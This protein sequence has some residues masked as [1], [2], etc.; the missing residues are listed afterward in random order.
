M[1]LR[2]IG[3]LAAL[4]GAALPAAGSVVEDAV[5]QSA[6]LIF[7]GTVQKVGGSN[8][9]T[10]PASENTV[11]VRVNE[12]FKSPPALDSIAGRDV[13]LQQQGPSRLKKGQTAVF[14]ASGFV[15]GENLGLKEVATVV[16]RVDG[17]RVGDQIARLAREEAEQALAARVASAALVVAG[18]VLQVAPVSAEGGRRTSEHD[19]ELWRAE[20]KVTSVEKGEPPAGGSVSVLFARSTDERWL[21]APKLAAQEAAIFLLQADET[22]ALLG[23]TGYSVLHRLDVQP[24]G[25]LAAVHKALT[26]GR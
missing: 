14:Y 17:D 11:V 4:L 8:V 26:T 20:L 25:A 22:V 23:R 6:G 21:F 13:T 12:L 19:P 10:L 3:I 18:E 5:A 9:K 15:Y 16:A 7:K 1:R 2:N 24:S